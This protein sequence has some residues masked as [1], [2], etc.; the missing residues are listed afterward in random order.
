MTEAPQAQLLARVSEAAAALAV[1][2][3]KVYRLME[4]GKLPRIK[5][6]GSVRTTWAAVY[7]L[8]EGKAA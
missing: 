7:A 8:A 4:A 2:D 1:S 6:E 5:I 3:S